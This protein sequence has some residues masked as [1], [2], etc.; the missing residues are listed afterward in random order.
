MT[1]LWAVLFAAFVLATLSVAVETA[2][3]FTGS[4]IDGP[5][6]V[7]NALRRIDA[8][9][10]PGVDFQFFHGLGVPYAHYWLYRLFGGGF[11]NAELAREV[12]SALVMPASLLLFFRAF[13]KSW[14]RILCASVI[15]LGF[16]FALRLYP[17]LFALNS[18]VGLRSTLPILVAAVIYRAEAT[19]ARIVAT[20]VLLGLAL[21]VSTE[22]GLAALA[23]FGIVALL[24]VMRRAGHQHNDH[25]G[26]GIAV[27]TIGTAVVALCV[28][29]FAVGGAAGVSGAL[30]Y[31][32]R[33]VPMD[34][35]WFFGAPPNP[36]ISS[37]GDAFGKLVTTPTVGIAVGLAVVCCVYYGVRLARPRIDT[38]ERLTRVQAFLAFYALISCVSLLGVFVPAYADAAW[39]CLAL[40]AALELLCRHT[41][42]RTPVAVPRRLQMIALAATVAAALFSPL[43]RRGLLFGTPHV[44]LDHIVDRKGFEVGG[45]WPQTLAVD[46]S[47]I[48]ANRLRGGPALPVWSTYAGW[49]E[50][51]AGV[52][53]PSFDYIIHPLGP[54][55]RRSYLATFEQSSPTLVQTIRPSYSQYEPWIENANWDLYRRLLTGYTV[56]SRTPWSFFW[57]KRTDSA[58]AIR[59]FAEG[60]VAPGSQDLVLPPAPGSDSGSVIVLEI[61]LGYQT[62]NAFRWLPIVGSMPRF[63]VGVEGAVTPM[64]IS[65][66]PFVTSARFPVFAR[67][68]QR[69]VLHVRTF[70]LLPGA[71]I[72]LR[73][74]RLST[75]PVDPG[76]SDWLAELGKRYGF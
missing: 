4:A 40:L 72:T 30:A 22:Q 66:D 13:E 55:N 48:G 28:A 62:R 47:I 12:L 41:D 39:R 32:F 35:Y 44:L 16:F 15:V 10:R 71:G 17:L 18:L 11:P 49:L 29:L 27:A 57:E 5:F 8:G 3:H 53:N 58:T 25:Q 26:F 21:F 2:L 19:K 61:E 74:L 50:A 65:L 54:D 67:P 31:N 51:R 76:N 14:A 45:I 37:W 38:D 36:F 23:A 63:L 46:D 52:F 1:A 75:V 70:S 6:Q 60:T 9:Q 24:D 69:P 64:P 33:A 7:Y 42:A 73:T 59:P 56:T 68:G 20:G 43:W 34:Q